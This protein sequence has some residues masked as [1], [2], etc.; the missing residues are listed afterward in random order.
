MRLYRIAIAALIILSC[1]HSVANAQI[2][3]TVTYA[4]Q[5]VASSFQ[6]TFTLNN[7]G[8]TP[9]GTFWLGWTPA[10]LFGFPYDLLPSNPT[11]ASSPTGWSGLSVRDGIGGYAVE[12]YDLGTPLSSGNSLTSFTITTPDS[13][14]TVAGASL[15]GSTYPV[16]TSW[17]YMGSA[18]NGSLLSDQ[19]AQITAAAVPE[20][21]IEFISPLAMLLFRRHR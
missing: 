10:S 16:S 3:A 18:Q 11:V 20:P 2:G 17:V 5:Q 19:G 14:T 9:I 4:T 7:T 21:V 12:W 1:L 13:P 6:Y 8:S 15:L